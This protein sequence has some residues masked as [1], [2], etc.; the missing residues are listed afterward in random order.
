MS[1]RDIE[2]YE[3][4]QIDQYFPSGFRGPISICIESQQRLQDA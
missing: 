4:R 2:E 1:I 3:E